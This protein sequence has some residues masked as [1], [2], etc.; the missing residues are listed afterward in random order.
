M[1]RNRTAKTARWLTA[2]IALSAL[3]SLA[4]VAGAQTPAPAPASAQ[5]AV[6]QNM[7][8]AKQAA[9][10]N[11]VALKQYTWVETT[12]LSLK[13]EVKSTSVAQV[14]YDVA[15]KL[16]KT[17]LSSSGGDAKKKP[18]L[19]GKA[20][21]SKT[22]EMKAYMEQVKKLVAEYLPPSPTKMQAAYAA[23][24]VAVSK[25]STD[26]ALLTFKDYAHPGDAMAMK[27]DVAS[28]KIRGLDVTSALANKDPVKMTVNF[29]A[30]PD[31][32]HYPAV[33]TVDAPGKEIQVKIE[34][35]NFQKAAK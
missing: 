19:R 16:Q 20:I 22:E 18:G 21:E 33:A 28:K 1:H 27:F 7:A 25:P 4:P 5:D 17:P 8:L 30:L 29:Q 24:H 6:K 15:G 2:A 12:T 11:Q 32:T 23:G 26:A 9:A 35:G 13:G 14:N 31:G 3:A 34:Q 10:D